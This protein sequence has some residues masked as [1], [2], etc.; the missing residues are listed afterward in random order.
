MAAE[1]AGGPAPA[2][3]PWHRASSTF[4]CCSLARVPVS[5]WWWE[6]EE[7]CPPPAPRRPPALSR[8]SRSL[9][10]GAC[11]AWAFFSGSFLTADNPDMVTKWRAPCACAVCVTLQNPWPREPSK[12]G[13]A[14]G[15]TP[16]QVP[17]VLPVALG[18]G[19]PAARSAVCPVRRSLWRTPG[20]GSTRRRTPPSA[21]CAAGATGRTAC[22]SATAAMLGEPPA[23]P[24][25]G[26]TRGSPCLCL[27][28]S[29]GARRT[30]THRRDEGCVRNSGCGPARP[31]A[32]PARLPA[33]PV[34]LGLS[35]C[36]QHC[37]VPWS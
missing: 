17:F 36:P 20:W 35:L 12:P 3:A 27:R 34:S 24:W 14:E 1:S 5:A 23:L 6:K 7:S 21:R 22:S 4:G 30:S 28:G 29:Q 32:F 15:S 13:A 16:E 9:C 31:G 2:C 11:L 25:W 37:S 33:T 26:C 8:A 18:P 19:S 10:A